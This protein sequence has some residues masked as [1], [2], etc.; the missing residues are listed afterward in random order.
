MTMLAQKKQVVIPGELVAQGEYYPDLNVYKDGENIYSTMVGLFDYRGSRISVIPLKHCYF[1]FIDDIII[2]KIID[3][4]MSGWSVDINSPY[5]A[6]LPATEFGT[7]QNYP[8]RR[9]S[10]QSLNVGDLVKAKIIAFDRTRDPLL[11]ARDRGLGKITRGRMIKIT[12][13]KIPR[14]IGKEGSMINMLKKESA[15]SLSVVQNGIVIVT[16]NSPKNEEVII[17]LI[18]MIEHEAHTQGLT[19]RVSEVI[20]RELRGGKTGKE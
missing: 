10:I 3:V 15:C 18:K 11:S 7:R 2:G 8:K 14:L 12:P 1:P 13:S 17:E 4:G 16:C 19:D 9:E 6:L 5:L 20:N